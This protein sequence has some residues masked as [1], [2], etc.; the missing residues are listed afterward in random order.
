ARLCPLQRPHPGRPPRARTSDRRAG[1]AALDGGREGERVAVDGGPTL[2]R[3][4]LLVAAGGAAG[5]A[6]AGAGGLL[7]RAAGAKPS[8]QSSPFRGERQAGIATPAQARLVFGAFDLE[9]GAGHEL[10]GLLRDWS[11]AAATL[12]VGRPLG[13][14]DD[15][16]P[17]PPVDT[18]EALG[19]AP[20]R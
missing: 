16:L 3:R 17:A 11:A 4:R 9:P 10:E 8:S 15:A 19:L 7:L 13:E 6:G 1:G 14:P 12:A 18:G 2:T 5:L 20:A